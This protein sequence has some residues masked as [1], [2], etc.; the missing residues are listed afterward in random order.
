MARLFTPYGTDKSITITTNQ[1]FVVPPGV[2]KVSISGNGA[3]G[4]DGN[5][6]NVQ[7]YRQDQYDEF[8]ARPGYL[9]YRNLTVTRYGDGPVP[10]NYCTAFTAT[11]NDPIYEGYRIC[12]YHSDAS[13]TGGSPTTTGATATAFGKSFPG[14][15]G[16]TA[17]QV[18][19]F[20]DIPV[21][22]GTSYPI[23]PNGGSITITYTE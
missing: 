1:N 8:S 23:A 15:Y 2:T 13:Y 14:S 5:Q 21:T 3:R 20:T 6:Y 18:L 11:P 17:P 9:N 19:I 16:N 22:P 10:T 12:L 7:R 4:V